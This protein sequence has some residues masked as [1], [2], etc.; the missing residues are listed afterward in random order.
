LIVAARLLHS[1]DLLHDLLHNRFPERPETLQNHS[2]PPISH[3]N[4]RK[5]GSFRNRQVSGSSPLVGSSLLK[6]VEI[7]SPLLRIC[8]TSN[9]LF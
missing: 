5:V 9:F 7:S 4:I 8:W 6:S 1:A 2:E 3:N